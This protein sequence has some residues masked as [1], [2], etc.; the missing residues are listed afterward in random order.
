[1]KVLSM[2]LFIQ[3]FARSFDAQVG[4]EGCERFLK[5]VG[6]QMA[7]RL[8]LPACA[9]MDALEREM[10]AALALM[11]WGSV[12]LDIDT[13]DR[14]FVLKHTGLPTVASVGEPSGY[15]LAPVLAG[16]Y[17]MWLEQ[18]PDSLPDARIS[19]TVE[20]SVSIAQVVVLT[21]GH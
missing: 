8:T 5:D 6:S 1:M 21:Y 9:T 7:T 18:Q 17:A 19:W 13:P 12:I 3:E 2:S 16:L 20:P 15:W 11:E 4:R 14:K 10:N